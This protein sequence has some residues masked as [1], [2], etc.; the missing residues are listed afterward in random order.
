MRIVHTLLTVAA[1]LTSISPVPPDTDARSD[2]EHVADVLGLP[3]VALRVVSEG[4]VTEDVAV[5]MDGNG[6]PIDDGTPFVW[7]SVSK[8]VT[9]AT[10]QALVAQ[11]RLDLT[12]LVE[13]VLPESNSIISADVTVADLIHHTGGLPHDVTALDVWG[14]TERALDVVPTLRLTPDDPGSFR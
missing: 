5:G 11:H 10:V 4:E 14:R 6:S 2:V 12:D 3:G 13:D 7:G 9:A 8:S 1:I